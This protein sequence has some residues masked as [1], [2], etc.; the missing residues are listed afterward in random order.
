MYFIDELK[1]KLYLKNKYVECTLSKK[2]YSW[3]DDCVKK[4]KKLIVKQIGSY[5]KLVM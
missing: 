5:V 1:I 2:T 4:T 3:M